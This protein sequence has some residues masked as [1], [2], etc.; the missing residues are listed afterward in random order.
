M[1]G[2]EIELSDVSAKLPELIDR[3][4]GGEEFSITQGGKVIA[5]VVSAEDPERRRALGMSRGR[6]WMSPDFN[7][8]LIEEELKEWGY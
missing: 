6:I 1:T 7:A 5:L 8:P 4:R 2:T 3:L